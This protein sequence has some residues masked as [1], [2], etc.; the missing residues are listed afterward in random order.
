MLKTVLF[1]SPPLF[2]PFVIVTTIQPELGKIMYADYKQVGMK[3]H[4]GCSLKLYIM[5]SYV[6]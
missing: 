2:F 4:S 5:I 6:A 1:S 3:V